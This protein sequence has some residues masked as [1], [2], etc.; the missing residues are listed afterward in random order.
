M[1]NSIALELASGLAEDGFS[2]DELVVKTKE[3]FERKAMAEFVGLLL[4]LVD[5]LICLR[6]VRGE[7]PWKPRLCCEHPRYTYKDFL[8]RTFRTSVGEVT[9]LWRRLE[10]VNC[11]A[12]PVPLREFLGLERYQKKTSELE[13]L[14]VEV[15]S[16]QS[17]RRSTRHL[18]LIGEIPVPKSTAHRWVM[19]SGCDRIETEGKVVDVLLP[20][21]T[22]YKRRPDPETG[23]NN[24]GEIRVV[25]GITGRGT[26]IPLGSWSGQSWDQIG[27][28]LRQGPPETWPK[29]QVLAADGEG[30]LAEGLAGLFDDYQRCHWHAVHDLDFAL[31]KDQA[32]KEERRARQSELAATIGIELP[33]G[34]FQKVNPEDKTAL[35]ERT[36]AA[37]EKIE[38]LIRDLLKKGYDRAADYVD[39]AKEKLFTYVRFWLRSGLI[40]PRVSSW[41][42]RIMREIGRRLKRMAFGWSEKGAEKITRIILR[43]IT[44]AE[45]WNAYWQERM[46]IKGNVILAF[47]GARVL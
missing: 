16:E 33:E 37:E 24:R 26:L 35:E 42:E 9:I 12:S 41:I 18:D 27:E 4:R 31:W 2:L 36:R 30:G 28:E 22:G 19:E 15:V 32:P 34:D 23:R 17:Y 45:A 6:L 43:R 44:D 3:L 21:G 39:R 7:G 47:R 38:A 29:A 10:C 8:S 5:E 40:C 46:G 20:D 1:Q 13:N 25:L 11:R 14:V